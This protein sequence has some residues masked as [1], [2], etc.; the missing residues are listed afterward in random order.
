[1]AKAA[2]GLGDQYSK[3]LLD[4]ERRKIEMWA[5]VGI[6]GSNFFPKVAKIVAT[7]VLLKICHF[8]R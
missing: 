5:D 6:N 7:A 3:I 4:G 2:A 8:S 1:M